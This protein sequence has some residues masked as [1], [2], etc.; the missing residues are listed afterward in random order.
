MDLFVR[1]PVDNPSISQRFGVMNGREFQGHVGVDFRP[2]VSGVVGDPI[3]APADGF[4]VWARGSTFAADNPW[5]QL[6]NNGNNGNSVILQHIAP[7]QMVQ[8]MYCHMD[9]IAVQEGQFVRAGDVIGYMGWTGYCL[10]KSPYGTHLHWEVFIDYGNGQYPAGTFYGR[11]DPLEQF[12]I[13][14]TVPVSPGPAGSSAGTPTPKGWLMALNDEQQ[15]E[16]YDWTKI[17]HDRVTGGIPAGEARGPEQIGNTRPP[18]VADSGDIWDIKQLLKKTLNTDGGNVL[19]ESN[20]AV[21]EDVINAV[22]EAAGK[23][24]K[25]ITRNSQAIADVDRQF[26]PDRLEEIVKE[27]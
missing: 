8:S 1:Y 18:R 21:R 9:R 17:I 4:V 22:A 26:I 2:R 10:P 13:A 20:R 6:P 23:V 5:E 7:F 16:L 12:A 27:D 19:L 25:D 3:Y 24:V 15:Q 11:V 14:T